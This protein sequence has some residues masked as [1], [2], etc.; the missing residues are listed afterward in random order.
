MT[1]RTGFGTNLP[2]LHPVPDGQGR[3]RT[4]QH[5]LAVI[6]SRAMSVGG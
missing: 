2:R 5:G 4:R 1:E 3:R 6:A